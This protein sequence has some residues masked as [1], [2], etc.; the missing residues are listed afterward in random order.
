MKTVEDI[1]RVLD[2]LAPFADAESW[3]NCG[4]LVGNRKNGVH[5]ALV[6]L[7]VTAQVIDEAARQGCGLIISHHPVIFSP[8]KAVCENSMVYR[9][10][11]EDIAVISAH[12]N[13]D[14]A[15][16]GVNAALAA[17][18]GLS[19]TRGLQALKQESFYKIQTFVP[20]AQAEA[21]RAAMAA[22]GAGALDGYSGCAYQ[23]MGEGCFLPGAGTNP[24]IGKVGEFKRTPE[25]K[26]EML[27][28]PDRVDAVIRALRQA[29]PYEV[30]AYDLL[31]N[32]AVRRTVFLG[33]VGELAEEMEEE[34]FARH[35]K[36]ALNAVSVRYTRA[37]RRI[38]RVAVCS[39]AGDV[40]LPDALRMGV[41]AFVTGEC[42]HHNLL[43]ADKEGLCLVTAGHF[44][45]ENVVCA[46]L[47]AMLSERLPEVAF[48]ASAAGGDPESAV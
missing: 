3:D 10:I 17:R 48:Y 13:L 41:D 12:T 33:L 38:R 36:Q 43:L 16:Q 23:T 25:V 6:A 20:P 8:L 47:A 4:I 26:L 37:G 11:R 24:A 28:A 29:H 32:S 2:G 30:P 15:G 22:A 34:A 31:A 19:N 39:G 46:P 45:T 7:D 14:V 21:V 18:L 1:Y 5:A 40:A 42:K 44:A 9:L 27:C 35:V